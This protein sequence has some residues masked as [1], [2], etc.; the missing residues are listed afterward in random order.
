MV[1]TKAMRSP[2]ARAASDQ[3]LM[4]AGVVMTWTLDMASVLPRTKS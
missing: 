4:A 2:R 3:A 1:G